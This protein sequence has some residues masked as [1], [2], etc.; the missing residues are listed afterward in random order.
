MS[1]AD[2]SRGNF[3]SID[4]AA[5]IVRTPNAT[6]QGYLIA[7]GQGKASLSIQSTLLIKVDNGG[8]ITWSKSYGG[9]GITDMATSTYACDNDQFIIVTGYANFPI[10]ASNGG[11]DGFL[12]KVP[13][14]GGNRFWMNLYGGPNDEQFN[15]VIQTFDKGFI[16]VGKSNSAAFGTKSTDM[17]VVKTDFA[18]AT[19]CNEKPAVIITE[20]VETA[21]FTRLINNNAGIPYPMLSSFIAFI[22]DK[23]VV[24]DSVICI[25]LKVEAGPDTNICSGKTIKINKDSATGGKKPIRF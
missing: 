15:D 1:L 19:P 17:Y 20:T 13:Y 11:N 5:K 21:N 22:P 10:A 18:G 8:L 23:V 6:D 24:P 9:A 16:A 12:L 25:P 7:G 14:N 2:Y 3:L 4:L